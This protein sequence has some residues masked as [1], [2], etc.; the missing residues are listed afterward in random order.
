M[1]FSLINVVPNIAGAS[2]YSFITNLF[3]GAQTEEVSTS[4]LD[5]SNLQNMQLLAA[6]ANF[7]ASAA[8]GGG[9]IITTNDK[10]ALVSENGPS[11]T[12]ADISDTVTT[13][14]ISK[15]T[16]RSGDTLSGV[17]SMFGVTKNT[18]IWVTI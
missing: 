18:I 7:D 2:I 9:D 11:G 1:I 17:A 10:E 6:T 16:V 14:Q 5:D 12:L 4:S 3:G 13:G 8:V 15:Y